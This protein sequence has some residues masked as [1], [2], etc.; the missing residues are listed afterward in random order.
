[1]ILPHIT[2][3]VLHAPAVDFK[4]LLQ[5]KSIKFSDL[6][7]RDFAEKAS[8][9]MLGCCVLLLNRG[10][11]DLLFKRVVFQNSFIRRYYFRALL[12]T[13]LSIEGL[14]NN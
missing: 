6:V 14:V 9:L 10:L 8:N 13:K 12:L 7:D 11:Y 5:Y 3:Q 1:M 2:K 4:H